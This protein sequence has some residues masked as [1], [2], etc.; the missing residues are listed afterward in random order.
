MSVCGASRNVNFDELVKSRRVPFA[1]IPAVCKPESIIC[2]HLQTLWTPA[3][4]PDKIRDSP[5][6]RLF[7]NSST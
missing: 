4:A 6:R 5:E 7:T 2:M 1:V 3:P